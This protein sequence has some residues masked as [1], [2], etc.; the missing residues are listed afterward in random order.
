MLDKE[1]HIGVL[2]GGQLGAM[3]I[4]HAVDFGIYIHVLD[5][6]TDS[7][8]ARYTS[9]FVVGDPLN[10][11]D[12]L[13]F[14]KGK[15]IMTIEKEAV[16]VD[17][18]EELA[19]QGVQVHPSPQ[20]IRIVQDKYSQKEFLQQHDI[21][22][23]GGMLIKD[24]KELESYKD[25]LP[26]CLKLCRDGYD[27]KGVM[28]LRTPA[29]FAEAFDAPCVLEELV[30]IRKELS[31]IV[32]RNELGEIKCYDPVEMVVNKKLNLLDYQLAPAE[33][34]ERNA[35]QARDLAVRTAQALELVGIVAVEMFLT[36]DDK[37]IVNELAP[38]PHNSGHHTIEACVT[39]QY[40]QLL[41]A[42]TGM[43]PGDTTAHKKSVMINIL[44]PAEGKKEE[45]ERT[46]KA[47]LGT[48]DAHLHWYGK[49]NS[50]EGRKVGHITVNGDSISEA[51]SKAEEI[52]NS[53]K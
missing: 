24:K 14:G 3:L 10:Y 9:N 23:A 43:P 22:V 12:V 19:K 32:S 25:R 50:K 20:V 1:I 27:G 37:V 44:E 51:I 7:N 40:E 36:Q 31:V 39:S 46:F 2:G 29:D 35:A 17:A 5:V 13:A 52:R 33:I 49:K 53:I 41:R 6:T 28:M 18:L 16:N 26:A 47:A 11:D 15:H 48:K 38:R 42:I 4:R 34:T 21:P 45:L 8:A 30:E